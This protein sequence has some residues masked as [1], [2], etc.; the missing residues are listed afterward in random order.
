MDTKPP[1]LNPPAWLFW[2][3]AALILVVHVFIFR[4]VLAA[5]G[6][7][8]QNKSS[9][10]RDELVPFF[11]FDKG[12]MP[13]ATSEL[14]GSDEFRVTYSFWTSWVRF[15]P[16]LPVAL[17]LVNAAA[18]YLLF[19]ACYRVVRHIAASPKAALFVALLVGV[20]IHLVLVYAKI[21]HFYSLILGFGMFALATSFVVE[22]LFFEKS[23]HILPLL[24]TILLVLF[25]PAIHYHLIFYL[26]AALLLTLHIITALITR[27]FAK[28]QLLRQ[29]L[30]VAI[31]VAATLLPYL[32]Y[33]YLTTPSSNEVFNQ[34]PVNYWMIFY[35]S[36]PLLYL[37]SFDGM[38]HVDLFRYGEYMAPQA[39][40]S[41]LLVFAGIAS[42]FLFKDWKA[43]A[44]P[45]KSLLYSL[46]VITLLALWM[47]IG[48]SSKTLVSFHAVLGAITSFLA[49]FDNVVTHTAEQLITV[50]ISVLRFP[51]RFQFIFYYTA[52]LLLCVAL[53][54]LY[55]VLRRKNVPAKVACAG[56]VLLVGAP[57]AASPAYRDTFLSGDFG[58]FLAPYSIPA[59]LATIKSLLHKDSAGKLFIMPSLESGRVINAAGQRYSFLDKYLIYYLEQPSIYNGYG[60][61]T[62]NKIV[63]HMVYRSVIDKNSAWE[64]ILA[65]S[66]GV[67]HILV[68]KHT[69]E[70]SKE[71]IYLPGVEQNINDSLA[72][73]TVF[74]KQYGG[75]DYDLYKL[76]NPDQPRANMLLSLPWPALE[77]VLSEGLS[78][79]NLYFPI[80][81]G[82]YQKQ[83]GDHQLVTDNPERSFYALYAGHTGHMAIPDSTL[84]PF[85]TDLTP[86]SNFT[87]NMFSLSTLYNSNDDYNYIKEKIPSLLNLQTAQF[88]GITP[89]SN[90]QTTMRLKVDAPG[91]YRIFLHAASK[92]A[93]IAAIVNEQHITLQ[94]LAG[95]PAD[96]DALDFTFYTADV[97]LAQGKN[98]I[99]VPSAGAAILVEYTGAVAKNDLPTDFTHVNLPELTVSPAGSKN[100][101]SVTFK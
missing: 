95:D 40:A 9:I 25:N 85:T 39:T 23:L 46:F 49:H 93:K 59:D 87:A 12:Y 94:R 74:E 8:A 19:Y 65:R 82:A 72:H 31:V 53:L 41:M 50:F 101:Y 15:N 54:W 63:S 17:V 27:T 6:D 7:V 45:K 11:S 62:G 51:H 66:L 20:A 71:T 37:L 36:I 60:A 48:F 42:V 57:I 28:K 56:L 98:D 80:Q 97:T 29:L 32:L 5:A 35:S 30:Y 86:S 43:L 100:T 76:K 55:A 90:G 68:P 1:A 33:I 73:S 77:A 22:Q 47:A 10:V 91:E 38:G 92:Q 84:L 75:N 99:V 81:Q 4:G 78:P 61:D 64:N 67:T 83:S 24:A 16:I 18:C 70:R 3:A 2:V 14:T 44:T 26:S 52:A 58:G 89:R 69:E 13:A 34:M 96:T 88:V 21:A 79:N